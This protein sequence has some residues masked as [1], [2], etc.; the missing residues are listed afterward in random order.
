MTYD[1][2]KAR[3]V[4]DEE[5]Q[6]DYE[7]RCMPCCGWLKCPPCPCGAGHACFEPCDEDARR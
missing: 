4:A 3:D 5:A 1:D 7:E 6:R 2:W